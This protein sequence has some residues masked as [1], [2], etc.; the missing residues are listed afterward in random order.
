MVTDRCFVITDH[1]VLTIS[2]RWTWAF[3]RSG[4]PDDVG[5]ARDEVI[6]GGEKELSG[7]GCLGAGGSQNHLLSS[8]SVWADEDEWLLGDTRGVH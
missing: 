1:T 6:P 7:V 2:G 4:G 5:P 8:S 3:Y